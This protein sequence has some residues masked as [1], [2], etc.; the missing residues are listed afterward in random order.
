[1]K[2]LRMPDGLGVQR[3]ASTIIDIAIDPKKNNRFL[4]QKTLR[5]LCS[6]SCL[7]CIVRSATAME[8]E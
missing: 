6:K 3:S 2:I 4:C 8:L 5:F 1:M 7:I